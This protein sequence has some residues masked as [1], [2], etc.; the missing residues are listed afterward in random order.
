MLLTYAPVVYDVAVGRLEITQRARVTVTFEGGDPDRTMARKARL[1]SRHFDSF[2]NPATINPGLETHDTKSANWAYPDDAPV[3]FLII[4]PPGFVADLAPFI[5]WKTS[6]GYHVTV[7]TTDDPQV[8]NTTTSIKNYIS[9][10][11]GGPNPPVYILMIGDSPI[12]CP[13]TR[14]PVGEPAE[15]ICHTS[16]WTVI[17]IRT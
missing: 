3:E 12:P 13:P 4:T 10:L 1:A 7:A 11:Y 15:P 5:E 9:G 17:S 8:G 6:T 14:R 16:K 2:I